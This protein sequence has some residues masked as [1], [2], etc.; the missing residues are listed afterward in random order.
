MVL[1][2]VR[3]SYSL[4]LKCTMMVWSIEVL[5]S[6]ER[7]TK[8]LWMAIELIAVVYSLEPMVNKY[9]TYLHANDIF[10]KASRR[11]EYLDSEALSCDFIYLS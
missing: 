6:C 9:N 5:S 4:G 3:R 11:Y 1:N 7:S 10:Q 2:Y 8:V